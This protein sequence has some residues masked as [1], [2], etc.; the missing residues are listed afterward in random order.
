MCTDIIDCIF[1]PSF[2]LPW[3]NYL[4]IPLGLEYCS[5]QGL[6][7]TREPGIFYMVLQDRLVSVPEELSSYVS[8]HLT[9][10]GTE[11]QGGKS[12]CPSRTASDDKRRA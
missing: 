7:D 11:L 10:D 9:H 12:G 6:E 3:L 1:L 4:G 5:E 8:S 2:L